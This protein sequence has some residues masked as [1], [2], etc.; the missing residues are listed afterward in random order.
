MKKPKSIKIILGL[1]A[2]LFL[3][4]SGL[5]A[6]FGWN[7]MAYFTAIMAVSAGVWL[8]TEGG[9]KG[10]KQ[11]NYWLHLVTAGIGFLTIYIGLITFPFLGMLTVNAI[12]N[13]SGWILM[14]AGVF[15]ITEIFVK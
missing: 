9:L 2:F 14:L 1:A 4:V 13:F 7:A 12:A 10:R 5:T 11:K 15:A 3:L 8:I 6:V